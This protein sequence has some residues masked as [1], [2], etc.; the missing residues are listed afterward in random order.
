MF[1][2]LRAECPAREGAGMTPPYS[3]PVL[4]TIGT[5]LMLAF[6]GAAVIWYAVRRRL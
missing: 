5:C 2:I 6:M 4:Y 1:T 3:A